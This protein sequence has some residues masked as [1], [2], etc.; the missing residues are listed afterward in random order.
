[1]DDST[2]EPPWEDFPDLT[3]SVSLRD[4]GRGVVGGGLGDG[5]VPC[6]LQ[7]PR[8][9]GGPSA[10]PGAAHVPPAEGVGGVQ[11]GRVH[12]QPDDG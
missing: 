2:Q 8:R 9:V 4:D 6:G 10:A 5:A 3:A 1:M 11:R 7:R 12:H